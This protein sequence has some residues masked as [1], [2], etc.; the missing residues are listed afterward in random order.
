MKRY[1]V[2]GVKNKTGEFTNDSGVVQKYDNMLL[3]CIVETTS[4]RDKKDILGGVLVEEIKVKNDFNGMVYAGEYE[5]EVDNFRRL[6]G[7]IIELDQNSDG[8]LECIEVVS[9]EGLKLTAAN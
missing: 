1:H 2:I 4:G 5:N 8:K 7:C 9:N 3:Q 6:I